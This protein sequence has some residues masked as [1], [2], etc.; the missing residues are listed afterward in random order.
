MFHP[1][2]PTFFEL[3]EQALSSTEQGYDLLA[4]KFEYTPFRTP[5]G[6]VDP[7]AEQL[8]APGSL[9]CALDVCCGTGAGMRMLRP[10]C[11]SHVT[12]VDLSRGMLAEAERL[13]A[14]APGDAELRF[15]RD[16]VLDLPF[17]A[18]FDVATCFGAL[19]HILERDQDRF[20]ASVRRALKPGGRFAFVTGEM[21][22]V[23]NPAW[24]FGRGFNAAMHVRNALFDPPFVMFYLT[25]QV[26]RAREV[27]ERNGLKVEVREGL[28]PK[29]R[30]AKLVIGT[31]V[32]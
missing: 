6:L 9:E 17:E 24:W 16:D 4:E 20:V 5:D 12:G 21:P 8:G 14:D 28:F 1:K 7:V 15:L 27:L 13:L 32:A 18:E 3:A 11:T 26:P 23:L 22:G 29:F 25:F 31:K 19:G 2:G 30:T 10:L